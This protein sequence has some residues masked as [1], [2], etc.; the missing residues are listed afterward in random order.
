VKPCGIL[1]PLLSMA[2]VGAAVIRA[3]REAG[4]A[5]VV[6]RPVNEETVTEG[7]AV[8]TMTAPVTKAEVDMIDELVGWVGGL[9]I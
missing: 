9:R 5:N 1:V 7:T 2:M 3:A 4:V 8:G 6:G